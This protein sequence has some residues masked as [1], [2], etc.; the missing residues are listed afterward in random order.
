[1]CGTWHNQSINNSVE[2]LRDRHILPW[3]GPWI[4]VSSWG[5]LDKNNLNLKQFQIINHRR[6]YFTRITLFGGA[7][8]G[9]VAEGGAAPLSVA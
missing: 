1:V 6:K 8:H 2:A 9:G 5:D 3:H 4:G 7:I